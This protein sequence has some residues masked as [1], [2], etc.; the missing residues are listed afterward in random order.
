[1]SDWKKQ[2]SSSPYQF[3]GG[4]FAKTPTIKILSLIHKN[5]SKN[6][7]IVKIF[8]KKKHYVNKLFFI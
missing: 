1:M 7:L 6:A 5:K 2:T 3:I 8:L 4:W